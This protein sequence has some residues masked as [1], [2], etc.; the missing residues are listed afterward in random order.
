MN[1][2]KSSNFKQALEYLKQ[3]PDVEQKAAESRDKILA[4]EPVDRL[5]LQRWV[6]NARSESKS[7]QR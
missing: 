5:N 2:E 1:Q 3:N 7:E 4:G 6:L